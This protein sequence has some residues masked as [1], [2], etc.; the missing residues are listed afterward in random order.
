LRE[1]GV[2]REARTPFVKCTIPEVN[3]SFTKYLQIP[4][5]A[6]R[7]Q[8][9]RK[10]FFIKESTYDVTSA[11][12]LRCDGCYYFRGDKYKVKDNRDPEAWRIFFEKE[13]ERGIN[14][15]ILAGA[16]PALVPKVL[17]A[18]YDV[19]PFGTIASNGLKKIDPGLRYKV[20]LFQSKP[21]MSERR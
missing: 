5:L 14:Y 12:Q 20:H 9:I 4:Q 10:Y 2:P 6:K 21:T 17:Q 3:M 7:Y 16:E 8:K 1:K 15:V 11:C 19:I 18:C 13:K